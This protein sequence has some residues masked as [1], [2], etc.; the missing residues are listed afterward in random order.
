MIVSVKQ[1]MD[2]HSSVKMTNVI[3]AAMN[4]VSK[5]RA[6]INGKMHVCSFARFEHCEGGIVGHFAVR[7]ISRAL[8]IRV[9]TK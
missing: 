8:E 5:R 6:S 2:F 7:K 1:E 3:D 4:W 9:S